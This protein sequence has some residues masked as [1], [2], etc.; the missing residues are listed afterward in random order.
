MLV[1]YYEME[2]NGIKVVL[3]NVQAWKR[4]RSLIEGEDTFSE[5]WLIG[6]EKSVNQDSKII[7]V[8]NFFLL[9][10]AFSRNAIE[11]FPERNKR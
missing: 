11:M 10:T 7:S 5:R 8:S 1:G 4:I 9:Y 6:N 2:E 3:E